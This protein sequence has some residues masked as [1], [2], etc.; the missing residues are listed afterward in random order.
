MRLGEFIQCARGHTVGKVAG[1]GFEPSA[2]CYEV[3]ALDHRALVP[4]RLRGLRMRPMKLGTDS[5]GF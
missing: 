5:G 1:S 2:V 3:W 4:P